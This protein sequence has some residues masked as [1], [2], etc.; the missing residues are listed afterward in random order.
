MFDE[1]VYT[2]GA[3]AVHALRRASGDALF[4]S[5]LRAWTD[6]Y[7]FGSVTTTDLFVTADRICGAVPGFDARTVLTP[8]LYRR[9]LPAL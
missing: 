3:L 5:F 1:R 7:R 8:W 4:F 2:R 6:E 9:P